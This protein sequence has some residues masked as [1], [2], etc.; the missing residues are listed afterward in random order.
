MLADLDPH[1]E[2]GCVLFLEI[3]GFALLRAESSNH[4]YPRK[5]L[6]QRRRKRALGLVGLFKIAAYPVVINRRKHRNHGYKNNRDKREQ[7]VHNKHYGKPRAYHY[8]HAQDF[9]QLLGREPLDKVGVLCGALYNI[10]RLY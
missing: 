9:N 1:I 6:L 4:P 5:V 3:V 2:Q 8:K 10:A 7:R